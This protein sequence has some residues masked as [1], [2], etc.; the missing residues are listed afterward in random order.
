MADIQ[1]ALHVFEAGRDLVLAPDLGDGSVGIAV[2]A[3][4]L[5]R[6]VVRGAADAA[7]HIAEGHEGEQ[8]VHLLR[9]QRGREAQGGD[10]EAH[11]SWISTLI[12]VV[13]GKRIPQL[14]NSRGVDRVIVRQQDIAPVGDVLGVVQI[15]H[16][17]EGV[18]R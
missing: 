5:K 6:V 1:E 10:V 2:L 4:I 11:L 9:S 14:Q 15:P 18:V 16:V 13:A 3:G 12:L 8:L 7:A 17:A